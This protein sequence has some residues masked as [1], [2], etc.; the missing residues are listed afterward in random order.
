MISGNYL[1]R[2]EVR[3]SPPQQTGVII[4]EKVEFFRRCLYPRGSEVD[5]AGSPLY[6]GFSAVQLDPELW[7]P[8]SRSKDTESLPSSS[9]RIFVFPR[10]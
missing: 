10:P 3:F 5:M 1:W 9:G 6:L 4:S 8:V 7:P 2:I